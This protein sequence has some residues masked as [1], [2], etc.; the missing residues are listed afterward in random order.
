MVQCCKLHKN[1]E[2]RNQRSHQ[3]SCWSSIHFNTSFLYN[4]AHP[5]KNITVFSNR[6]NSLLILCHITT[7]SDPPF[8]SLLLL[9]LIRRSCKSPSTDLLPLRTYISI[10]SCFI[11]QQWNIMNSVEHKTWNAVTQHFNLHP[12]RRSVYLCI[13]TWVFTE[14]WQHILSSGRSP[15]VTFRCAQLP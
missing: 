6:C 9:T 5:T 15:T 7:S 14:L 4:W 10:Y 8:E 12:E 13:L 11:R 3:H 1:Q 2:Y